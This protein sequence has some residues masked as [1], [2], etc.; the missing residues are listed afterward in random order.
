MNKDEFIKTK[1]DLI[2]QIDELKSKLSTLDEDYA[3]SVNAVN[4]SAIKEKFE[5]KWIYCN[6]IADDS[7]ANE[8][9]EIIHVKQI[10]E[11]DAN[12]MLKDNWP[13]CISGIGDIWSWAKCDDTDS[14]NNCTNCSTTLYKELNADR[15]FFI[16]KGY[17]IISEQEAVKLINDAAKYAVDHF[18]M[19]NK[20]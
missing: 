13:K 8:S 10:L 19:E 9:I 4:L 16:E 20:T 12:D 3:K 7:D 1:L 18:I 6:V 14:Y 2:K 17:K 15:N 11:I 5:G